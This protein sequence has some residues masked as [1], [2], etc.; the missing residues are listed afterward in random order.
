MKNE[1]VYLLSHNGAY[2]SMENLVKILDSIIFITD[3]RSDLPNCCYLKSTKDAK[4]LAI[5]IKSKSPMQA[6]L[7]ITQIV[8]DN[9]AG[10]VSNKTWPFLSDTLDETATTATH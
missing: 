3:W 7:F 8:L 6:R 10:F 5:E 9:C 2:G 4:S 1:K